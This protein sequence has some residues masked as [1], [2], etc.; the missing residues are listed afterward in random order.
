MPPSLSTVS[1]DHC[2]ARTETATKAHFLFLMLSGELAIAKCPR[3][4]VQPMLVL[5]AFFSVNTQASKTES[6][7]DYK[8]REHVYQSFQSPG[9]TWLSGYYNDT[10]C[11]F[12]CSCTDALSQTRA[13]EQRKENGKDRKE[14]NTNPNVYKY[15]WH[16][17]K[18]I[19][20]TLLGTKH[21][22]ARSLWAVPFSL[23][24]SI[25]VSD[26]LLGLHKWI[27]LVHAEGL[28]LHHRSVLV[29]SEP[30]HASS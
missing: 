4:L 23:A 9:Y 27:G 2:L 19:K 22:K 1:Q 20:G 14:A 13:E 8:N 7:V 25:Q 15:T 5:C 12:N 28:L 24:F 10:S 26:W 21:S 17:I 29:P 6:R 30:I 3:P 11:C 16:M 18:K